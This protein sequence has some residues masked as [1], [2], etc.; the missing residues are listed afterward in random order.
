M[1]QNLFQFE[2]HLDLDPFSEITDPKYSNFKKYNPLTMIFFIYVH[3]HVYETK[4]LLLF[5]NILFLSLLDFY[6]IF[7]RF[8]VI[9]IRFI[10]RIRIRNTATF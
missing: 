9:R 5:K 8:F 6:A 2:S 7:L 10:K 1:L 3:I 4:K